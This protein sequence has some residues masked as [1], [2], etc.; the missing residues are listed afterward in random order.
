MK[1]REIVAAYQNLNDI[2]G[3]QEKYPVRFSY[4]LTRNAK[5]L[6][7][8]MKVFEEERNRLLD[9]YNV[10]DENGEPQY[11]KDGKINIA[12]EY[13]EEWETEMEELLD[14]EVEF[15]PQMIEVTDLP[16][17]VEPVILLVLDFMIKE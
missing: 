1:N 12:K 16:D 2:I 4:A 15:T 5:K 6:E 10:K 7:E 14:I 17:T 13:R 11:K 3:K 8:C 9:R